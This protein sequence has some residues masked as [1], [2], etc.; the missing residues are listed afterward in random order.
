MKLFLLIFLIF[1]INNS[2]VHH[3]LQQS[4]PSFHHLSQQFRVAQKRA[5]LFHIPCSK[6]YCVV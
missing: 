3:S 5:C 1:L 2:F 4:M 6:W